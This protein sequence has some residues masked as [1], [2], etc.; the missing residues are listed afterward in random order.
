MTD[1]HIKL[2]PAERK[3]LRA[4]AASYFND[5]DFC[6]LPFRPLMDRTRL[7]RT[8]VRRAARSLA[9]KELAAYGRGLCSEDGDF[10]GS[11]YACTAKGAALTKRSAS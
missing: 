3:V 6:F 1:R 7:P 9:R 11:G 10:V 4:L 2:N 5:R 8:E